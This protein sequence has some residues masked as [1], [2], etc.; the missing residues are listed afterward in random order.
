MPKERLDR[1]LTI[2]RGL[3]NHPDSAANIQNIEAAIAAQRQAYLEMPL[4]DALVAAFSDTNPADEVFEYLSLIHQHPGSDAEEL[5][6]LSGHRG[7]GKHQIAI[8]IWCKEQAHFLPGPEHV[9]ARDGDFWSGIVC[10]LKQK[11]NAEDR[12]THAWFLKESTV[13][14]LR[15]LGRLR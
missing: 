6:V 12:M 14:A 11:T 4:A 2:A 5:A 9:A 1:L 7:P 15:R 8:G 3:P 10:S 13:E